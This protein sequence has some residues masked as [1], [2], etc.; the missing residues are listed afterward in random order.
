M[1]GV[2]SGR[3][4]ACSVL[5]A[6]P[7]SRPPRNRTEALSESQLVRPTVALTVT[8]SSF[9]ALTEETPLMVSVVWN[10]E[11]RP[12]RRVEGMGAQAI[13]PHALFP[14]THPKSFR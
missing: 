7:L 11:T 1:N 3:G 4:R 2:E 6:S 10:Q 12:V 14:L 13:C 9:E 8:P 5:D